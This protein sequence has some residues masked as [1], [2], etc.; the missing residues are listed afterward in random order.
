MRLRRSVKQ[1]LGP[2]EPG[3]EY[4]AQTI[5]VMRRVL[6]KAS[7]GI[8]IGAA[9]GEILRPMVK[10][11]PLGHHRAFEP[12]PHFAARLRE[13]FP[14]VELHQVALSDHRGEAEFCFAVDAPAFSGLHR[15]QYPSDEVRVETL[16]VQV[17]RLDDL[18]DPDERIDFIKIDV[19]GAEF[20]VLRGARECL[21]RNRPV[22]VFEYSG[23]EIPEYGV[24]N[25]AFYDYLNDLGMGI[26]TLDRWLRGE[27]P[28][29]RS[30]FPQRRT[31]DKAMWHWMYVAFDPHPRPESVPHPQS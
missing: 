3:S 15:R 5:E 9:W 1:R 23:E 22:V 29:E 16:S 2:N 4:D 17:Q 10:L 20:E 21:V 28:L 27:P 14:Q 26:S 31:D 12:L 8:D 7:N 11:A 18:I 6:T 25:G 24:E 30:E 13:E 19:E